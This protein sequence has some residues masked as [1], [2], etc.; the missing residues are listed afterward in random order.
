ME[1]LLAICLGLTLSAACGFRIFVPPLILSIA[2]VTGQANVNLAPEFAW[3]GTQPALIAFAVAAGLE[4]CAYYIPF[5]DN[6]LDTIEIP[7]ALAMGTMLT[8]ASLGEIDPLLRWTI[9]VLGGATAAETIQ[10][11]T[12]ITR[13]AST[14]ITGGSGNFL[15]STTEA[16]SAT[17]LAILGIT[18]P[19][20]AAFIVLLVLFFALS[21]ISSRW[22]KRKL[23]KHR[24]DMDQYNK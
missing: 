23:K 21:K 8:S 5:V 20:F 16:F 3:M 17:V 24:R 15:V 13:L 1:T 9:A 6:L 18:L 14:G 10:A 4:I 2:A 19:L 22:Q 11:F 12:S 7:T